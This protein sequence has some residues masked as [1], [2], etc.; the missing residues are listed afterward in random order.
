MN[1][2]RAAVAM[3]AVGG[4]PFAVWAQPAAGIQRIAVLSIGTDPAN[5]ARWRPFFEALGK[6]GYEEGR[7]LRI[8]RF[9]LDGIIERLPGDAEGISAAKV[10]VVVTTG[11]REVIALRKAGVTGPI[12]FTFVSDPVERGFVASLARPGG[13]ITGFS[14]LMVG[15][16]RKHVELLREILP[17]A[18]RFATVTVM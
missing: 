7:N 16:S 5:P 3:L 4:L 14:S 9:F 2:R 15:L 6:L 17:L 12:V 11:D 10:D 18:K 8:D 1:R 13:N